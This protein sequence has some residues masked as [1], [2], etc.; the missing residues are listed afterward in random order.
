MIDEKK[1]HNDVIVTGMEPSCGTSASGPLW[2]IPQGSDT[3]PCWNKTDVFAFTTLSDTKYIV[4]NLSHVPNTGLK[5][6]YCA[7]CNLC[8]VQ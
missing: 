1:T 5:D 6:P 3:E 7:K 4:R 8:V 2:I